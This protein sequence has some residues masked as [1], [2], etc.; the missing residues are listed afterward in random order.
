MK[1]EV[2]VAKATQSAVPELGTPEK[3]LYYLII[4]EGDSKTI[5]NIGQ[6]T[7]DSISKL[8]NE[9]TKPKK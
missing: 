7:Y 1:Q 4:G 6:K 9:E 8:S 3:T 5:I 2:K